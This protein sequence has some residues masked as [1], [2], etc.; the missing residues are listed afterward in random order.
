MA[1]AAP[2]VAAINP[3]KGKHWDF[4]VDS[5]DGGAPEEYR[6]GFIFSSGESNRVVGLDLFKDGVDD[7]A[8]LQTVPL[9]QAAGSAGSN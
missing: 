3:R 8:V 7:F 4:Y 2:G 1:G 5:G 9:G 6:L